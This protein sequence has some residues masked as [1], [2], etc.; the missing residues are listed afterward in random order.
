MAQTATIYS[1]AIDLADMDRNVYETLQHY[2]DTHPPASWGIFRH[3]VDARDV[4]I[5][6]TGFFL[7]NRIVIAGSRLYQVMVL[8]SK[9]VVTSASADKFL[10]SFEVTK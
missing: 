10:A 5:E 8:G 7:R 3:W 9:E 1:V 6:K 4:L 2:E